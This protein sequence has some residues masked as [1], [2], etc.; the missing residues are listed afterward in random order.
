MYLIHC[1]NK[2]KQTKYRTTIF[3]FGLHSQFLCFREICCFFS[4]FL[5]STIFLDF[6]F[7]RFVFDKKFETLSIQLNARI[8][9][10]VYMCVIL[11]LNPAISIEY[12]YTHLNLIRKH[13]GKLVIITYR[14]WFS[15]FIVYCGRDVCHARFNI[16]LQLASTVNTNTQV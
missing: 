4:L 8:R 9:P 6:C 16:L 14:V 15:I 2:S 3:F 13:L 5:I 1:L 12:T 7:F 11:V 10:Y